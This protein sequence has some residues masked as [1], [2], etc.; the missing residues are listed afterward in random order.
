MPAIQRVA[1]QRGP[2]MEDAPTTNLSELS[3]Q[4]LLDRLDSSDPVPGGG[5]AAAIAG[6]MGAALVGMVVSL[7]IGRPGLEEHEARL[8]ALGASA[9]ESHASL[10]DLAQ[11]DSTA[12]QSVIQARRMP[13]ESDEQR[14]ARRAAI[15]RAMHDAAEAPMGIARVAL[16]VLKD[17]ASVAPI[18]NVNAISDAGVAGLLGWAGL[19]GA[20]LNVQINL[21]YLPE[22]DTLRTYAPGELEDLRS[23]GDELRKAV[24]ATVTE[25]M[26]AD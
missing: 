3:I 9:R 16:T 10:L 7:T 13:R 5:S 23:R 22:D 18:G 4:E 20:I 14:Q 6:A 2:E 12:Y 24:E 8:A 17:A 21:P 19:Q 1:P 26:R 25:R 11:R 15:G